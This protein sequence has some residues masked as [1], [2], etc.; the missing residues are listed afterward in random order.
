MD[1]LILIVS[2]EPKNQKL[3]CD[4]LTY[5]GYATIEAPDAVQVIGMAEKHQ[6][7]LILMDVLMPFTQYLAAARILKSR[8]QTKSIPLAALTALAMPGDREQILEAGFDYCFTKP[9]DTRAFMKFVAARMGRTDKKK[10]E[11]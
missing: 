4:L 9:L 5:A 6:P 2:D 3:V 8:S 7:Q 11:R 1:N 10:P